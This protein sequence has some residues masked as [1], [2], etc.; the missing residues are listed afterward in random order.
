VPRRAEPK[1]L[2]RKAKRGKRTTWYQTSEGRSWEEEGLGSKTKGETIWEAVAFIGP[3]PW[4]EKGPSRERLKGS[5]EDI[6]K[7]RGC[8]VLSRF[9]GER[10]RDQ[11]KR[12]DR[13]PRKKKRNTQPQT[14]W[15]HKGNSD[16]R[17]ILGDPRQGRQQ[18]KTEKTE[19]SRDGRDELKCEGKREIIGEWKWTGVCL[20]DD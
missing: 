10:T 16:P 4:E 11:K 2:F 18:Q 14:P 19:K 6:E 9:E 5:R 7:R 17:Q 15:S 20:R 12:S 1:E 3:C 8:G 13:T